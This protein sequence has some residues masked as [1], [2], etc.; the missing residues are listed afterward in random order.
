MKR[1]AGYLIAL[2]PCGRGLGPC[3]AVI[4]VDQSGATSLRCI[5]CGCVAATPRLFKISEAAS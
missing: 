4:E 5:S 2:P 1:E 3:L